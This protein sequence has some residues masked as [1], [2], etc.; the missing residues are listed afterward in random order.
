MASILE[1]YPNLSGCLGSSHPLNEKAAKTITRIIRRERLKVEKSL[2]RFS[3]NAGD[4]AA[5]CELYPPYA[6]LL[7][8]NVMWSVRLEDDV[9]QAKHR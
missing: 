3:L 8:N 9:F 6:T 7:A 5:I 1:L 2:K 4:F